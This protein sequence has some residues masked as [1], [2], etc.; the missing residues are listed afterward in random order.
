M[1]VSSLLL[2]YL[3]LLLEKGTRH[4]KHKSCLYRNTKINRIK[5]HINLFGND[6]LDLDIM[7]NPKYFAVILFVMPGP[8][9]GANDKTTKFQ[10]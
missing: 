9:L 7:E 1:K 10:F 2:Y 8:I 6:D 3:L 5:Y 4:M